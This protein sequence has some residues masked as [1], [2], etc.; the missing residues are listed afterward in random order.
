MSGPRIASKRSLATMPFIRLAA[1]N[2]WST[3]AEVEARREALYE[4]EDDIEPPLAHRQGVAN[5]PLGF[6]ARSLFRR[7]QRSKL[8][9]TI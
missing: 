4:I 6:S 5:R 2:G 3:T 7:P 9:R 1:Q 8:R